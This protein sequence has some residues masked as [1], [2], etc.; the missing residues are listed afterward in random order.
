MK[1]C[2]FIFH[3]VGPNI[4]NYKNNNE[5]GYEILKQTFIN[6][7]IH[8]ENLKVDSISLPLLCSGKTETTF[9]EFRYLFSI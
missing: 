2:E 1:N 8:C 3:A 6:I 7:F 4:I 5:K 9:N